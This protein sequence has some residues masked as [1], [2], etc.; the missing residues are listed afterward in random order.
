MNTF[1]ILITIFMSIISNAQNETI[2]GIYHIKGNSPEGGS[3]IFVFEDGS[4]ALTYFGGIQTGTWASVQNDY[5]RFTPNKN[6]KGFEVYGRHHKGL[7][8]TIQVFFNGFDGGSAAIHFNTSGN[9]PS[10]KIAFT[11]VFNPY[12]NCFSYPY[13]YTH[14]KN[15]NAISLRQDLYTKDIISFPNEE[16][17]NHFVINFYGKEEED[18]QPFQVAIKDNKMYFSENVFSDRTPLEKASNEDLFYIKELIVQQRIIPDHIYYN[19]HY[20]KFSDSIGSYY[21]FNETKN[22]FIN[23]TYYKEGSENNTSEDLFHDMSILYS[24]KKLNSKSIR[25]N[26]IDINK[27]SL[28]KVSCN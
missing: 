25:I 21:T 7:Q 4:Y 8:N 22:A 19:P 14:N 13:V 15:T 18:F 23:P 2:I 1:L 11:P 20:N 5:Y 9:I 24:F 10:Q 6:Q 27:E 28:F 26:D 17:F 16:K 12:A 3:D